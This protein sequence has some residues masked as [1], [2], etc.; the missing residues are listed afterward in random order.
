M[1]APAKINFKIY[2]GSTFRETLRWE[3]ATKV[4]LPITNITKSAP[5][6]VTTSTPPNIP[7]GWRAKIVGVLGM[8]EI[9]SDEY[10]T[11]TGVNSNTLVFNEINSLGYTTYTSGGVVEYN[12]PVSLAFY[13]ARMQIRSS[14]ESA[15]VLHELT[16]ENSGIIIDETTTTITLTIPATTTAAFTWQSGVYNLELVIGSEVL[17]FCSGNLTVIKEVTR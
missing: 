17:P 3:S 15:T 7:I 2:Q 6:Q 8:K 9:N 14:V 16:T 10:R 4:Y 1:A 5:V 11:V 13:A 12:S